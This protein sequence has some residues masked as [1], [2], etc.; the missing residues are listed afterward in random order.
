M[1]RAYLF[2]ALI[3]RSLIPRNTIGVYVLGNYYHGRFDPLYVGRSDTCLLTR[4]LSHNH[5]GRA[6]HVV[7]RV[8]RSQ[9]Q[10]YYQECCL[11]HTYEQDAFLNELI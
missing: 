2:D 8:T 11:Y 10:A 3:L 6:T 4:L 7:W 9:R 1:E 5:R